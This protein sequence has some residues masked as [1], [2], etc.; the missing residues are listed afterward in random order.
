MAGHLFAT[1]N[2]SVAPGE[3]GQSDSST[4]EKIRENDYNPLKRLTV[5]FKNISITVNEAGTDYGD[6][7]LSNIDPRIWF[8]RFGRSSGSKKVCQKACDLHRS[9]Q[10][11]NVSIYFIMSPDRCVQV[12]W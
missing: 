8:P 1:P 5:T 9:R 12:R 2:T 6:T 4:G 7:V 3:Y 11:T 10:L